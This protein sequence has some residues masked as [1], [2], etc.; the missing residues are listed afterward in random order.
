[1]TYLP[2]CLVLLMSGADKGIT[3]TNYIRDSEPFDVLAP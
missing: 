3:L 2:K 1:M